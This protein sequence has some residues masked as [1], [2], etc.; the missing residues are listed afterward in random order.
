MIQST[1]NT[2][3]AIR[4]LLWGSRWF[5]ACFP[6]N[7]KKALTLP[8][9]SQK[10]SGQTA[11]KSLHIQDSQQVSAEGFHQTSTE[12][13]EENCLPPDMSTALYTGEEAN[14]A[15]QREGRDSNVSD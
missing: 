1:G 8:P 3:V 4:L 13:T 10:D 9:Q 14:P 11:A 6:G 7:L 2:V 12:L 5:Q 15:R